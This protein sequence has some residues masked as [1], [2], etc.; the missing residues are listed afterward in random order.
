MAIGPVSSIVAV[1]LAGYLGFSIWNAYSAGC[2]KGLLRKNKVKGIIQIGPHLSLAI[3]YIGVIIVVF[4]SLELVAY[5]S[6]FLRI[7]LSEGLANLNFF[8]FL[9]KQF[10]TVNL[11]A[12]RYVEFLALGIALSATVSY[13][14]IQIMYHLG[15]K[16]THPKAKL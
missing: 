1:L 2:N 16:K 15:L 11:H 12:V 10:T 6:G 3:S 4:L 7:N 14:V 5:Y 9:I 8:T 13:V